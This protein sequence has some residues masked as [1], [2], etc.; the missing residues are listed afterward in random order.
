MFLNNRDYRRF[1]EGVLSQV[2]LSFSI[3]FSLYPSGSSFIFS[4]VFSKVSDLCTL[5]DL[6]SRLEALLRMWG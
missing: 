6:V 3:P 5:M 1:D 4:C 2:F